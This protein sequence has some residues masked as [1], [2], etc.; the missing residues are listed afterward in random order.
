MKSQLSNYVQKMGKIGLAALILGLVLIGA[1]CARPAHAQSPDDLTNF[2]TPLMAG[3]MAAGET[4]RVIVSLRQPAVGARADFQIQAVA[5]VQADVL[6][7]IPR[8]DFHLIQQF[9]TLP[10]LAGEVTPQGL[11]AL[12]EHPAVA[13]IALDLPVEIALTESVALIGAD[14]VWRDWGFTGA[15]VNVAVLDTGI[16]AT[17][18]DLAGNL[19]AQKCFGQGV[20]PPD[21]SDEGNSAEDGNGH[22]THI[23][24]II[25]GGGETSPRGVAPDTGIVAVRVMDDNGSGFTS[26]V[27]TAIDWI[28]ANHVQLKVKVINLSLGGG[29]YRGVCDTADANTQ[30]YAQAVQ[31]AQQ[32][33][34]TI[35]AA[36]GN[37]GLTD[38]MMAPACVSGVIAVGGTYDADLGQVTLGGCM[39]E[40]A[41]IDQVA[42]ASNSSSELD[43][44]APGMSIISTAL[45]G[46]Q[47]T[48]SG[49]SMSTAHATAVAALMVQAKPDLTPAEIGSI[50]KETGVPVTDHRNGRVSPRIDALAAVARVAGG[51]SGA[52]SGTVLLQSR[53]DHSG[54]QIFLGDGPCETAV[55]SASTTTT[56]SDGRFEILAL[57]AGPNPQCLQVIQ[58]GF[59]VGQ[60]RAPAGNLGAIT[61]SGGEVT[62]DGVIDI[63]DLTFIAARYNSHDPLADITGDG[64]VDIFDLVIAAGNYEQQGPQTDW[65]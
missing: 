41:T 60:H 23:A 50:L 52:I 42:C 46:G 22:G 61:L 6:A 3:E 47:R 18:P 29:A 28:I 59:L 54:T 38:E 49:T 58:P 37:Q 40:N 55:F 2:D 24:G 12:L 48:E 53:D 30:L 63:F 21:N 44:L 1:Q 19:V 5:Q 20:C 11:N 8:K 35:F 32:A 25:T 13:A 31:L 45:G 51:Q 26:D 36:S 39:D 64:L 9:E 15:G 33:G 4:A 16:D 17:H 62:G 27:I 34:I 57:P 7:E 65:R 43:L 10:G 14:T 56:R